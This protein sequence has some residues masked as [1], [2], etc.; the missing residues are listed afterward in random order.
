MNARRMLQFAFFHAF[1]P[2]GEKTRKGAAL[3]MQ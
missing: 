3:M 2:L 1:C